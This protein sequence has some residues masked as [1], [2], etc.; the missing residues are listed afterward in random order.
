MLTYLLGRD[1]SFQE[2]WPTA[3]Y[4]E[5]KSKLL[6]RLPCCCK[7]LTCCGETGENKTVALEKVNDTMIDFNTRNVKCDTSQVG[8][9]FV[10]FFHTV[11]ALNLSFKYRYIFHLT[12][13]I[14]GC[15]AGMTVDIYFCLCGRASLI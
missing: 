11:S 13:T 12:I 15:I 10:V 1:T 6:S 14:P 7:R 5:C 3:E 8:F 4:I 2:P 9:A